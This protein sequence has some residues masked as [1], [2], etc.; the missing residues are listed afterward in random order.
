MDLPI[1]GHDIND[2]AV[3][4]ALLLLGASQARRKMQGALIQHGHRERTATGHKPKNCD[5]IQNF[6]RQS[7][8]A[9]L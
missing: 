5:L 2:L 9:R 1:E 6:I 3:C 4:P 7:Y 8:R